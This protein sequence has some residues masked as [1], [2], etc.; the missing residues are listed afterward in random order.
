MINLDLF[1]QINGDVALSRM[2]EVEARECADRIRNGIVG[3]GRSLL[4]LYEREGWIA[5]GY[6]NWRECAQTEFG[7]RQSHVY[8]LLSAAEVERN[9]SPIGENGTVPESHLRPLTQLEPD[10]QREVYQLAVE[11]APDGRVTA[12]HIESVVQE[13]EQGHRPHVANNSGNNEWYTPVEYIEAVREVMGN[14]DLDPASSAQANEV[15]RADTFYTIENDGLAQEW[16]GRVFL[17]PPYAS[18]LVGRFSEKLVSHVQAGDISQAIVLVN[19]ATETE[20]FQR[21]A[22]IAS[23]I[24][25]PRRR[26]RFWSPDGIPGAPLQGQAF[27]YFGERADRFGAHFED[28]GIVTILWDSQKT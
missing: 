15:V 11:T 28:F 10:E 8:R 25:F 2:T 21:M 17:N 13:R 23:A 14:I 7:F 16:R 6:A 18:D 20:W 26:V 4:E 9:I 12:A 24:C 5:L 1:S 22:T 3:I 27:L 19:N